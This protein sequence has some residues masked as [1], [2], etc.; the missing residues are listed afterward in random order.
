V[1]RS[2]ETSRRLPTEL[3]LALYIHMMGLLILSFYEN[4]RERMRA[5]S[6]QEFSGVITAIGKDVQDFEISDEVY[7]M[8]DMFADEATAEFCITLLQNIGPVRAWN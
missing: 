6:G 4:R 5:V 3:V 1:K 7:G 2:G 8:N